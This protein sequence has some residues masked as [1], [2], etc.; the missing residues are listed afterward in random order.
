MKKVSLALF[1]TIALFAIYYFSNNSSQTFTSKDTSDV[2]QSWVTFT[3][4]K[5]T[6]S[7]H[8]STDDELHKIGTSKSEKIINK[9]NKIKRVI[10]SLVPHKKDLFKKYLG[11]R[12][13]GQIKQYE[14]KLDQLNFI[15]KV[16]KNW[17]SKLS[18]K[19]L[20]HRKREAKLLIKGEKSVLKL[21]NGTARYLELVNITFLFKGDDKNSF[22]AFV[23]SE[24]GEIIQTWSRTVHDRVGSQQL[25]ITPNGTL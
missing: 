9:D 25:K 5:G 16:D 19:L 20:K 6:I 3:N 17:K 13:I 11:R 22:K 12:L 4:K 8:P 18:E 23:D 15:N 24:T 10:S 7:Q 1:L 21:Y 14:D 2:D